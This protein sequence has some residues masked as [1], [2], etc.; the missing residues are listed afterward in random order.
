MSI[1]NVKIVQIFQALQIVQALQRWCDTG[2]F[3]FLSLEIGISN[4]L[5]AF[6]VLRNYHWVVSSKLA[7]TQSGP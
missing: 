2:L 4:T 6:S 5:G 1:K 7:T 3:V